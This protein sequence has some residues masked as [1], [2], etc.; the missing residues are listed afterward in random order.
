M[1]YLLLSRPILLFWVLYHSS[2]KQE[3]AS[4][5]I[6]SEFLWKY[7]S[8]SAWSTA[9]DSII[10]FPWLLL[11]LL[12]ILS[13]N[14]I[15]RCPT[16]MTTKFVISKYW[17]SQTHTLLWRL[18]ELRMVIIMLQNLQV[19][20]AEIL[21]YHLKIHLKMIFTMGKSTVTFMPVCTISKMWCC[22][23]VLFF[24][25]REKSV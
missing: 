18:Q 1:F 11:N 13:T 12:N 14:F 20:A 2:S 24:S 8:I 22:V 3:R 10:Q 19:E 5:W 15:G 7:I 4:V 9:L 16:Q 6:Q 17:L 25:N 21:H 23:E